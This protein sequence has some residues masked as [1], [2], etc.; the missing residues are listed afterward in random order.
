MHIA[1]LEDDADQRDFLAACLRPL[2]GVISDF[3][4]VAE[5]Q[6]ALKGE[7]FDLFIIDWRLPEVSGLAFIPQLRRQLGWEVPVLMITAARSEQDVVAALEAG[8]DDFL[9]KPLRPDELRARVQALPRRFLRQAV[10]SIRTLGPYRVDG[11]RRSV[12]LE[13]Q[14]VALTDREYALA[15]LFMDHAGELF[16][17]G[18]L[19]ELVWGIRGDVT[20]RTVDTHVSRLRRKLE[21]DGRHGWR[22]R[23]V[24][25]HGYR[26]ELQHEAS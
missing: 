26:L 7:R 16:S 15:S 22:L 17:R 13:E 1:I 9:P 21:L 2:G 12:L 14:P 5:L 18:Q 3:A 20:T 24:Y 10:A 11:E 19:L 8:A 4:S 25:Q 6:R 23:S